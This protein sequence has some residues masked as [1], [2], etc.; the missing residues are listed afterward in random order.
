MLAN[1]V[2]SRDLLQVVEQFLALAEIARPLIARTEGVGIGVV[3]CVD[4]ATGI[5]VD[6]PRAT[7]FIVLFDD[8]VGDAQP[9]QCNA[10]RNGADPSADDQN[11]LFGQRLI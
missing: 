1:A 4:A 10:K 9:P 2:L 5:A 7:K 8:G 6:V 11:M 3:R